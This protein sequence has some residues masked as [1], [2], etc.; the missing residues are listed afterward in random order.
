MA[1]GQQAEWFL[2]KEAYFDNEVVPNK[3]GGSNFAIRAAE[4]DNEGGYVK[5][6]EI[7]LHE[8]LVQFDFRSLY[9]SII[10]SK[11]F[12]QTC[13]LLE[14]LKIGKITIF[15]PEH[16]LKFKR[17]RKVLFHQLYLKFSMKDLKLKKL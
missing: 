2:V 17:I 11:T 5:E 3:P 13:W 16:D 9:P 10:I 8:N 14:M 12:L 6:P 15:L 4:E 1:T 7:G